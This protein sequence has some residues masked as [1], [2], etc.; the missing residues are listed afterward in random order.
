MKSKEKLGICK[1]ARSKGHLTFRRAMI[2]TVTYFSSKII[3]TKRKWS[4]I[5][6]ALKERIKALSAQNYKSSEEKN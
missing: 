5:F 2:P 6:K 4:N 1:P 3:Q